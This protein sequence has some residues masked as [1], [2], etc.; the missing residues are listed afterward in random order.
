MLKNLVEYYIDI[1]TAK[2][3]V[4]SH[5]ASP[6][7]LLGVSSGIFR[8]ALVD[9]SGMIVTQVGTH[10]IDQKMTAVHGTLCTIPPRNSNQ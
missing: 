5:Q 1:S 9:E 4:I 8:R 7:S 2:F 10:T 3:T 6:D